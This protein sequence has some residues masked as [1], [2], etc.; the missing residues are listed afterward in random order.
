MFTFKLCQLQA[1]YC[2]D[3][4]DVLLTHRLTPSNHTY[5]QTHRMCRQW[6][7]ILIGSVATMGNYSTDKTTSRLFGLANC[8][9]QYSGLNSGHDLL[10]ES[11]AKKLPRS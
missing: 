1:D 8:R 4:T 5:R 11:A 6:S 2:V 7:C 10:P 3:P 9:F